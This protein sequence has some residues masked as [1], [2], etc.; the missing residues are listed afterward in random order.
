ML[1]IYNINIS[2]DDIFSY[3]DC[4]NSKVQYDMI[5]NLRTCKITWCNNKTR[6]LVLY[7]SSLLSNAKLAS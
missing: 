2:V 6:P 7:K 3:I 1:G 4:F 5:Y